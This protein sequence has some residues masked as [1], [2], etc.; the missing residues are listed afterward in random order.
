MI[1]ASVAGLLFKMLD[2][3]LCQISIC[4][5][6]MTTRVLEY[7]S[8]SWQ[9][10]FKYQDDQ[11]HTQVRFSAPIVVYMTY[12]LITKLF[13]LPDNGKGIFHFQFYYLQCE[14]GT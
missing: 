4:Y 14:G 6:T 8:L 5:I 12:I 9:C 7:I 1:G 11:K 13:F 10:P 3:W 2:A